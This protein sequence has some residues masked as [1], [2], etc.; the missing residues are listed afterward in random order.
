MIW[1]GCQQSSP[2]GTQCQG[3]RKQSIRGCSKKSSSRWSKRSGRTAANVRTS[4][5]SGT[6][7]SSWLSTDTTGNRRKIQKEI[8]KTKKSKSTGISRTMTIGTSND[9]EGMR[10]SFN[11]GCVASL[12]YIHTYSVTKSIPL[13]LSSSRLNHLLT[14]LSRAFLISEG[15]L[16]SKVKYTCELW[17]FECTHR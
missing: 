7:S 1:R 5:G 4:T 15:I 13:S 16:C 6:Y 12:I 9:K 11:F 17:R 2:L 14:T 10:H 3:C 8:G